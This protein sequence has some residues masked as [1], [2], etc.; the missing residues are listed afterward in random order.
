MIQR[1]DLLASGF[2]I[3]DQ[4]SHWTPRQIGEWL[5]FIINTIKMKFRVL[6]VCHHLGVSY[7]NLCV[8]PSVQVVVTSVCHHLSVYI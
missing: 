3:N 4:K 2:V 5:G 7:V 6:S 8:M 1:K